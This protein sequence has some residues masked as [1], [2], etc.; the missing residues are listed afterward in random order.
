M[1]QHDYRFKH[2]TPK[3]LLND[4]L[5]SKSDLKPGDQLP[6]FELQTT[7]GRT[8]TQ[9][10]YLG[11]RPLL[12]F[13]GSITCPMTASA[14]PSLKQLHAEYGDSVHFLLLNVREAHPGE[15]YPQPDN[16][17]AK[18]QHAQALASRYDMPWD[19]VVDGLD[20]ELHQALGSK[21]NS[22]VLVDTN[23]VIV[24]RA[25][26]SADEA[27]LRRALGSIAV[28]RALTRRNSRAMMAPMM[29]AMGHVHGTMSLAGRQAHKDLI[30]SAPPMAMMGQIA[31][32][33]RPFSPNTRGLA[34]AM[35]LGATTMALAGLTAVAAL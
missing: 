4:L 17:D 23:G 7:D 32:F 16:D 18:L 22:A 27:G 2:F 12:L 9:A 15:A 19:V 20:G 34:A 1:T 10:D 28:G 31:R 3:L 13:T 30:R 21:P 24:F 26:W 33:F 5:F 6:G 11:D 29:R 8:V 14:M 35:T 25:H